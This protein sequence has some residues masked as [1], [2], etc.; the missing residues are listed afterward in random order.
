MWRCGEEGGEKEGGSCPLWGRCG[1]RVG[2]SREG[3][4][5]AVGCGDLDNQRPQRPL[6]AVVGAIDVRSQLLRK[7]LVEKHINFQ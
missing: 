6:P 2:W 5:L 3:G 4:M 7:F 1:L